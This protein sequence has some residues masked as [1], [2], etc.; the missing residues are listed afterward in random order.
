MTTSNTQARFGSGKSVL[1]VE[2]ES[3]LTGRGRFTDDIAAPGAAHMCFLRSPHAHA[4]IL[5]V[6]AA[7]ALRMPGVLMVLTGSD[8]VDAGVKPLPSSADFKRA[9]GSP[10]A[11]P[12]EHS[13]AVDAVR[14]VG[15]AVAAVVASTREQARE[16][17]EAIA[18]DYA[19]LPAVVET[20]A[21]VALGAPLVWPAATGNIAAEI[22]HGD[23]AAS[24]A[25][26][27]R[28]AHVVT[29]DLLN[30]RIA[31]SPMEPRATLADY[32]ATTE[33][34][35]LQVSCQTP[36]GLRDAFCDMLGIA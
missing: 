29:L 9:D 4:R 18:V 16:A 13:L 17:V 32:D 8:L 19:P 31:P 7:A 3:L 2:D 20:G 27:A 14:H 24:D 22:R 1:R 33:R 15:E 25:A 36:T 11:T 28:A 21:A 23:V 5:A 6:D 10:V 35:T 34:F 26:F 30:Q 12:P